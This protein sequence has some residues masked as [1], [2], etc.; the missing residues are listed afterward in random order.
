MKIV[1]F[2]VDIS[3]AKDPRIV[4]GSRIRQSLLQ[5][6]L[7]LIQAGDDQPSAMAIA[8][9]AGVSNQDLFR[10][11]Q[12]L[13]DLYAA[14]FDLAVSRTFYQGGPVDYAA[15]LSSRIELLVSDRAQVFEE[16]LPVWHFAERL[17]GAAPAIGARV[18]AL[19]KLLRDRLAEWFAAELRPLKPPTRNAVLDSLDTA[20]GLD[21]WLKLR[22]RL[23]LSG[24]ASQTW[25]FAAQAA[26]M[27]TLGM[28]YASAA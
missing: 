20:F 4:Q 24:R 19:R 9:I 2:P 14:A 17:E 28:T 13:D 23:R 25:R 6:T 7:D 12:S 21:S 22:Q 3:Q 8:T 18:E 15:S 11:F 5:A 1:G 16:W 26:A 27:Q 10:F